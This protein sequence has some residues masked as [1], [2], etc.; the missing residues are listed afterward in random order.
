VGTSLGGGV[1]EVIARRRWARLLGVLLV[2]ASMTACP[3]DD[4]NDG[5]VEVEAPEVDVQDDNDAGEGDGS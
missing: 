2:G 4:D 3:G 1:D 5:E